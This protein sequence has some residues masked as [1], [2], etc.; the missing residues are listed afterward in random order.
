V[1]ALSASL[2]GV[3]GVKNLSDFS[4]QTKRVVVEYEIGLASLTQLVTAVASTKP[5]HGEPY[6]ASVLLKV[7]GLTA[8]NAAAVEQAL[9]RVKG[10]ANAKA[11]PADCTVTVD[12]IVPKPEDT[13]KPDVSLDRLIGAVEGAT[14]LSVEG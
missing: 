5:L 6:A 12:L 4:P 3:A 13:E 8:E 2:Q 7:K 10:V 11:N 1:R 9:K 14:G